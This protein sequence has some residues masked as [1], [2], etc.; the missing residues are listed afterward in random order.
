MNLISVL[1]QFFTGPN[2]ALSSSQAD[3][4]ANGCSK[5]AQAHPAHPTRLMV[6]KSSRR[7]TH[8][9]RVA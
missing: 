7:H 1:K 2:F 6:V 8:Y 9:T 3:A 4:L 5:A